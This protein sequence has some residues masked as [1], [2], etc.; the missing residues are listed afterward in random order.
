[1]KETIKKVY[2]IVLPI[3]CL[4]AG[5]LAFIFFFCGPVA[6][7]NYDILAIGSVLMGLSL[8]VIIVMVVEAIKERKK[9]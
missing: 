6:K 7:G 1:M 2:P 3:L 9:K 5:I 8:I 4:L